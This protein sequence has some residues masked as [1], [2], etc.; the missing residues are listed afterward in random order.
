MKHE[1]EE[2]PVAQKKDLRERFKSLW[3]RGM[4]VIGNT[5]A[6]IANN[7]RYKVDEVTLQNRRREV[8]ND[9]ANKAYALWLKGESFPEPMVRMLEELK[10][11]DETLNDMRAEKY[12]SNQKKPEG[13]AS[14]AAPEA[15]EKKEEEKEKKDD[16]EETS[17]APA[18]DSPVSTEIN[19][20]F[21]GTPSVGKAAEK[22]NSTLDQMSNRIRR[23]P[24]E[25][26]EDSDQ[27][28]E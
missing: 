26:G 14:E 10:Q 19:E 27:T 4:K 16:E 23:F 20:L 28:Q 15:S 11:L 17:V 1:K 21:D 5:A 22:V 2:P 18:E 12:A 6:S 9:L 13:A 25:D 3:I 7:T 8:L 24:Q